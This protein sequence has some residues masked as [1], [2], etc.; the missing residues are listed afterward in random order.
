MA[1]CTIFKGNWTFSFVGIVDCA[2]EQEWNYWCTRSA[3]FQVANIS[4]SSGQ[5]DERKQNFNWIG[6]KRNVTETPFNIP[7]NVLSWDPPQYMEDL[8]LIFFSLHRWKWLQWFFVGGRLPIVHPLPISKLRW[9]HRAKSPPFQHQQLHYCNIV[10]IS[11][12]TPIIPV[13]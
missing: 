10:T 11:I 9:W 13:A 8:L 5:R 2:K 1:F 4:T 12:P 7:H 3:L 6:L